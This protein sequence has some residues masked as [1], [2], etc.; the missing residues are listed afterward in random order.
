[1]LTFRNND[2]AILQLTNTLENTVED[3]ARVR[4]KVDTYDERFEEDVEETTCL[5]TTWMGEMPKL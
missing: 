5:M 4:D 3:T 2:P 1:M